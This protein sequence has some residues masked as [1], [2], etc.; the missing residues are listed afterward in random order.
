L[1]KVTGS[2]TGHL[3]PTPVRV[4]LINEAQLGHR[5]NSL[6]E[7]DAD[8]TED[9]VDH[10]LAAQAAATDPIYSPSSESNSEYGREVYMVEQGGGLPEKTTKEIQWEAEEGIACA[11]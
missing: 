3:P 5:F 7:M 6:E 4:G 2:G 1:S 11:K 10:T 8:P 9:R